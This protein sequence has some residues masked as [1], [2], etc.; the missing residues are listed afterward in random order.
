MELSRKVH[1][2]SILICRLIR[3]PSVTEDP[4]KRTDSNFDFSRALCC[5]AS[6][7]KV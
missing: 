2:R 3:K 6:A 7:Y 4:R 5:L 1:S